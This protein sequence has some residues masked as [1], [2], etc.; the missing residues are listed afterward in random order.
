MKAICGCQVMT[1][2]N[3]RER[4]SY[5]ERERQSGRERA[6]SVVIVGEWNTK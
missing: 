1:E 2:T 3:M 5:R 6:Q 4:E